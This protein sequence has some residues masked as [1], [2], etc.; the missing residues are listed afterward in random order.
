MGSG[1]LIIAALGVTIAT[2]V[3]RP[4]V[5]RAL[6]ILAALAL[7]GFVVWYRYGQLDFV[8]G[9]YKSVISTGALLG[10]ALMVAIACV[11]PARR[12]L[13]AVAAAAVVV[14]WAPSGRQLLLASETTISG[15]RTQ[16]FALVDRVSSLPRGSVVLVEGAAADWDIQLFQSR[17]IGA[18]AEEVSS[19]VDLEGLGSTYSYISPGPLPEWRPTQPWGYTVQ[20]RP[21]PFQGGRTGLWAEGVYSLK[22]APVLDASPYGDAWYNVEYDG[23][24][25]VQW[26]S[27]PSEIL[28]S[29]RSP[30][31]R[32][33]VLSVVVTSAGVGRRVVLAA[34]G[35]QASAV[36]PVGVRTIVRLAVAVPARRVVSATLSSTP[37]ALPV[38]P[39]SRLRALRVES[40]RLA[41]ASGSAGVLGRV[42]S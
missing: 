35:R 36:A 11:V 2:A 21:S 5:R 31:P 4:D 9:V 14:A 1:L 42:R 39:D 13:A 6:G 8:Y 38:P 32:R 28:L 40:V 34:E 29:N 12:L 3:R 10:G 17:M 7:A 37:G 33:A 24:H 22:R 41:P 15:F 26:T 23:V 20:T 18:F 25:A 27:G 30:R 19:G 16:D